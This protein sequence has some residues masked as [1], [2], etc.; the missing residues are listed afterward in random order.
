MLGMF[1]CNLMDVFASFIGDV[2]WGIRGS[3]SRDGEA[4]YL[5]EN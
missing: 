3:R 2:D 4:F 1:L 5:L